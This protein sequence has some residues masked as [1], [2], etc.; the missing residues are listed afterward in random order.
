[1]SNVVTGKQVNAPHDKGYKKSLSK[2]REFLHFLKKYVR[3]DWT[4]D[5]QESQL[6]LADKEYID[7]DY[8]GR[9][10][11]LVYEVTRKRLMF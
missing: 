4:Q 8:E 6:R 9:E 11:D 3:A 2:P 1:M 7:K 5:L 10:A